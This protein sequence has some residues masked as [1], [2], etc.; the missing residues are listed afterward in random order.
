[1]NS[2]RPDDLQRNVISML[3][4][5]KI[6]TVFETPRLFLEP[7]CQ[8]HAHGLF[9]ALSDPRLYSF[10]PQN[11]PA[12]LS[13]LQT[14]YKVLEK[15]YSPAGK[16]LWLNWAIKI[17]DRDSYIGTVQA[18]IYLNR[19]ARL[20]YMLSADFWGKGYATEACLK[21]IEVLF[22][23]NE[24]NQII[25][26]VD[27]RNEASYRLLERLSFERV[28]VCKRA[29]FFKGRYSDEYVYTLTRAISAV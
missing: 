19:I 6:E 17:R 13:D 29:D 21:V 27:T 12:S 3:S 2:I 16:E 28:R 23:N 8:Q 1:M 14:R 9:V 5:L 22:S 10:I 20:A 11:P 4:T 26:E 7:L 18:T 15:R 25:A 24:V